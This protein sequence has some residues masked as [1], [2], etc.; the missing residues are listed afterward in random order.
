MGSLE[1]P[2]SR[3]SCSVT[4][5]T[6]ARINREQKKST[7]QVLQASV[8]PGV[9]QVKQKQGSIVSIRKAL[10]LMNQRF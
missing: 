8:V 6:E 1:S 3:C 5:K 4:S 10:Q 2:R 9:L 7:C